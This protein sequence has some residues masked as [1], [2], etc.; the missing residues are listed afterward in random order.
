[1]TQQ[2]TTIDFPTSCEDLTLTIGDFRFSIA[3]LDNG[4]LL[5]EG[6]FS[7]SASDI[8]AWF[9][10]TT[11]DSLENSFEMINE[12]TDRAEFTEYR[13][14]LLRVGEI[15]PRCWIGEAIT[16]DGRLHSTSIDDNP[17]ECHFE[18][19]REIA[20]RYAGKQTPKRRF[21]RVIDLFRHVLPPA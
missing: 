17:P 19:I 21:G 18:Q 3:P 6:C 8:D 14:S 4:N 5:V 16:P 10:I 13:G 12:W 11:S 2:Q 20:D 7:A 15:A 1:M 9:Y